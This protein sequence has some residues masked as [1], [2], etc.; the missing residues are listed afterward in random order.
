MS[1]PLALGSNLYWNVFVQ[2]EWLHL[3][4]GFGT[5][6]LSMLW[7]D[8]WWKPRNTEIKR[9]GDDRTG[10]PCALLTWKASS[11]F[12]EKL[13]NWARSHRSITRSSSN[14]VES[15][16]TSETA[17]WLWR[18]AVC[19]PGHQ[20]R[21]WACRWIS[22]TSERAGAKAGH[23][24]SHP[25][26]YDQAPVKTLNTK[27]GVSFPYWQDFMCVFRCCCWRNRCHPHQSLGRGQVGSS[28]KE[29]FPW[30][31][32]ASFGVENHN[33]KYNG[34]S[35]FFE[36]FHQIIETES[37]LEDSWTFYP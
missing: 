5:C 15:R 24:G 16:A 22:S 1:L 25:C 23:A 17:G 12:S 2:K 26:A 34:F 30:L 6:K 4:G 3:P 7:C 20:H 31:S 10:S 11:S 37:G 13:A 19:S 27:A 33:H 29:L 18:P 35:K 21:V 32:L 36:S 8:L 28:T 9:P 14:S